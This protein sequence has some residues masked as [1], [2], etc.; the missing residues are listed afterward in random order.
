MP[1]LR[2]RRLL[3]RTLGRRLLNLLGCTMQNRDDERCAVCGSI[4]QTN[5]SATVCSNAACASRHGVDAVRPEAERRI[6]AAKTGSLVCGK[7]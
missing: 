1:D 6:T 3:P 7:V 2:S 5:G 4:R